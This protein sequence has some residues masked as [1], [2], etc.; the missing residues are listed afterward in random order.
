MSLVELKEELER[1]RA[2]SF[3]VVVDSRD[4]VARPHEEDILV[5]DVRGVGE[6]PLTEWGH[7]CMAEK[8][9]IPWAY[10]RRMIDRDKKHLLVE[11]INE[12]IA[13]AE[14]GRV[15]DRYLRVT[16]G[17]IRAVLSSRFR[18]ID[19]YDLLDV[20]LVEL[21]R[22]ASDGRAIRVKEASLS[23][24]KMYV[25]VIDELLN[26][27]VKSESDILYGGVAVVNS[28][29]GNGAFSVNSYV[30]RQICRNGLMGESSIRQVHVG[31]VLDKGFVN[32]SDETMQRERELLLAK[33]RDVIRSSFSPEEFKR[34][35]DNL[36]GA[37]QVQVKNPVRVFE[38]IKTDYNLSDATRDQLIA[39]LEDIDN[40]T[41]YDVVN[42]ITRVARHQSNPDSRAEL[43]QLGMKVLNLNEVYFADAREAATA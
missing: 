4:I 18:P 8:L 32:W 13:E 21:N 29:V 37:N 1:Q 34:A 11:N 19:N 36:K 22:M 14:K 41:Q 28:E 42:S 15:K 35:V 20:L 2:N 40:P 26:D 27:V 16:N 25:K 38:K 12:W 3:D 5:L 39:N 33:A 17:Q 7:K 6:F 30:F 43:E 23:D 31:K 24:T 10:Y 9:S